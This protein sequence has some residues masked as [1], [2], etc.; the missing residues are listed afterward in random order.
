MP[1][2]KIYPEPVTVT[3]PLF[4]LNQVTAVFDSAGNTLADITLIPCPTPMVRLEWLMAIL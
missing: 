2:P 1:I 4:M 3:T